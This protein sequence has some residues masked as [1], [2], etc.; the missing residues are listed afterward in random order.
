MLFCY[1]NQTLFFSSCLTLNEKRVNDKRHVF[2]CRKTKS[3]AEMKSEGTKAS[4]IFCCAGTPPERREDVEGFPEKIPRIYLS[5]LVQ[6]GPV[7]IIVLIVFAVYLGISIWGAINLKQGLVIKDLVAQDSYYYKY[8]TWQEDHFSDALP[9]SFVIDQTYDYSDAQIQTYVENIIINAKADGFMSNDIDISWLSSY[10]AEAAYYDGSSE[11]AFVA[12]LNS[13]LADPRYARFTHDVVISGG[14]I[15]ASRVYAFTNK[16]SSSQDDAQMMLNMRKVASDSPLS[17]TAFAPAF[18]FYEQY[19]AILPQTLQT[20]GIGVAA[21]FLITAIFMPH[22]L[23]L[24]YVVFTMGMIMVGIVGFMAHW[25]LT[26][27]SITMIHLIMSVGFSVDFTAHIC[28]AYMVANGD[29]RNDRVAEAMKSAGGPIFNGAVSSI[30][31]I[32]MLAFAKSYIFKSFFQVMLLVVLFGSAHALFFLP[33]LLSL[34][35]PTKSEHRS[36]SPKVDPKNQREDTH[37]SMH[38]LTDIKTTKSPRSLPVVPSPTDKKPPLPEGDMTDAPRLRTTGKEPSP[39]KDNSEG[40][41][42]GTSDNQVNTSGQD[43]EKTK[44]SEWIKNV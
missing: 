19:I 32:L 2:C 29:T 18:I 1:L 7:K 31:G 44:Y 20:L 35:G 41:G 23:L 26:L 22:P 24:L 30:L 10:K 37:E 33:V 43:V 4:T 16:I 38:Q 40:L 28:H 42:S 11:A 3:K 21:V 12:G 15:T 14:S 17:A 25:N 34:I 39:K 27:S 9:V 13:F 6:M 5:K 8:R 36:P